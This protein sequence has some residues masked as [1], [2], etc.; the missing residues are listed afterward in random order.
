ME[1]VWEIKLRPKIIKDHTVRGLRWQLSAQNGS[2]K[3]KEHR[4]PFGKILD[5]EDP[6][7]PWQTRRS[8]RPLPRLLSHGLVS[9]GGLHSEGVDG[10]MNT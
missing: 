2:P 8:L 5:T 9:S 3:T 4:Q 10:W 7:S 1:F 6:T